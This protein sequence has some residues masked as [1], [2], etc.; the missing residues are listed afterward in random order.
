MEDEQASA[1]GPLPLSQP[2]DMQALF[3]SIRTI[4]VVGYS[5]KPERA[6]NF[7]PAYLSQQGYRIIAVNPK[8][9]GEVDGLPAYPDL[10]SIP[11]SEQVDVIDVFRAPEA[12]PALVEEAG[13][14]IPRP[15]YF[16]MQPGAQNEAAA[17][18]AEELGMRPLLGKCMLAEHRKLSG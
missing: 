5:D 6:G 3:D 4:A 18:R 14:M 12:V 2:I 11:P 15:R 1:A 13:A 16:W 10:S 8:F 9:S 17:R 7:V